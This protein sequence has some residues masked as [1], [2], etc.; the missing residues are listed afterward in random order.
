[1]G[2]S[3]PCDWLFA[4]TPKFRRFKAT[5]T[6][7]RT[8][9]AGRKQSLDIPSYPIRYRKLDGIYL[10]NLK[11]KQMGR[12]PY[13]MCPFLSGNS[14]FETFVLFAKNFA[15]YQALRNKFRCTRCRKGKVFTRFLGN[16]E[17]TPLPNPPLPSLLTSPFLSGT[18]TTIKKRTGVFG[19]KLVK[20]WHICQE[21]R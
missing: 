5:E 10:L 15:A 3:Q 20:K 6:R 21:D 14:N 12:C 7:Q 16:S 19:R 8:F 2:F 9:Y 13:M 1:M 11:R 17:R 18:I 4:C